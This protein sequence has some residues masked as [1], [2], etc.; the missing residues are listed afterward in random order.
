MKNKI[1]KYAIAFVLLAVFASVL[2]GCSGDVDTPKK[3]PEECVHE[4]DG[5]VVT[6]QPTETEDGIKTFTCILCNKTKTEKIDAL[7]HTH[8][9]LEWLVFDENGHYY[10]SSCGH[11]DAKK[12]Y[13]AHS[14]TDKTVL[15][16][17]TE[18]G[19]TEHT[20]KCGYGYKD[21]EV[22]KSEDHDWEIAS[23]NGDGTH[24]LVCKHSAEHTKIENCTYSEVTVVEPTC[25]EAGYTE[26]TCKCGHGYKDNE[27][28]S[29]NHAWEITSH[30]GDGTHNLVC[31][32]SAEHI[33]T[34]TC[35]YKTTVTSPTCTEDGYTEHI[36]ECGQGYTDTPMSKFGHDWETASHNDDGTRNAV[37][38]NDSTHTEVFTCVYDDAVTAPTCTE[39]GY[40]Y[41]ICE[42]GYGYKHSTTAKLGHDWEFKS[43]NNNGT[44]SLC[45]KNDITHI[46]TVN[47]EY[48]SL[49][50]QATCTEDGYTTYTCDCGYSYNGSTVSSHG[51]RWTILSTN[52]D[53][54][55]NIRCQNDITHTDKV[56]CEY[57]IHTISPTCTKDGYKT[58]TCDCGYSYSETL[59]KT[60][61]N[62]IDAT[63]ETPKTCSQC[64]LTEGNQLYHSVQYATCQTP[65][66]CSN[67]G[68]IYND[69]ALGGHTYING[70]CKHCGRKQHYTKQ[71]GY[72]LLGTYPQTSVTD[73]TLTSTLN[74]LAGDKPTAQDSKAW[75]SYE[76]Y[77]SGSNTTDYT[78][79]IDVE[80]SGEKYRGVYFTSYRPTLTTSSATPANGMQYD[81][82]YRT[83][84]VYWFKYE[85]IK[86][87]IVTQVDGKA[88]ILC[89]M[90]LDAQA[91]QD[92]IVTEGDNVYAT[93]A[94]GNILTDESG[95]KIYANNYE[96]ST[97]RAWLN[98][99]FY[100][101]VF[102]DLEKEIILLSTV[103]ND[104]NSTDDT[105]DHMTSTK[106]DYICNNTN[107]YV[108]LLSAEEITSYGFGACDKLNSTKQMLATEYSKALG[109][110]RH[111]SST[112]YSSNAWWW[113][114]SPG[115]ARS[116][117]AEGVHGDGYA[118]RGTE[119]NTVLGVCPAMWIDLD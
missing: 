64:G 50:I 2:F 114:R 84:N 31:K 33:K 66:M 96:Y 28:S 24:N 48:S 79:Y 29:P 82:R 101:N 63:C 118:C 81:V 62:W 117:I 88:L 43:S 89:T 44:H 98:S 59:S 67:C 99:N 103:E 116:Y 41:R 83:G 58:Y 92:R 86:W 115:R 106:K 94:N 20:C 93:D 69:G 13:S 73:T 12:D 17:C 25:T 119:V 52:R 21:S 72:I 40:T 10:P 37:C 11:G 87:S 23:H 53:G 5:G 74:G 36:C 38:K 105:C 97:I 39:D 18:A 91:Y 14:F 35:E 34:E 4:W 9:Y 107:D 8:T 57:G 78:W 75:T 3:E 30:N 45:C 54:T 60:G 111:D 113:L 100:N 65:Q 90:V 70:V 77:I 56:A 19:Y 61:H 109:V 76:Y 22:A 51:H 104:Y 32:H 112:I 110:Y 95:N 55:H 1:L 42:C 49:V 47:C 80:Y 27:V 7:T 15:P 16:T 71:D 108:F 102:S 68:K 85:P 6:V 26:H 46:D